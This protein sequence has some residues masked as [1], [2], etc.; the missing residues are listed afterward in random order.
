MMLQ[1]VIYQILLPFLFLF[2]APSQWIKM[3]RRKDATG[4]VLQRLGFFNQQIKNLLTAQSRGLWI[5][6]VSVGEVAIAI[7][8]IREWRRRYPRLPIFLTTT[9]NTAQAVARRELGD[10]VALTYNPLDFIFSVRSFFNL[11][12]PRVLV[13]VES[14]L[15]PNFLWEAKRR[16]VP[17]ALVNARLSLTAERRY[18][19]LQPIIRPLY[20]HLD[21]ICLQSEADRERLLALGARPETLI[22]ADS[23]KFDVSEVRD[24]RVATREVNT[25]LNRASVPDTARILLGGS[26]HPGEEQILARVYLRLRQKHPELFLII[27]P[28]HFER[29]KKIEH[30]LTQLGLRVVRRSLLGDPLADVQPLPNT[31]DVLL[32]DTTGELKRFYAA[33]HITFV[34]KSLTGHGGQNFLEPVQYCHPVIV[35]PHVENFAEIAS[36]FIRERAIIQVADQAALESAVERCLSDPAYAEAVAMRAQSLFHKRLGATRRTIE[37]LDPFILPAVSD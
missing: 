24:T 12:H 15:W 16:K 22:V 7:R 1:K 19:M 23:M 18:R 11:I 37:A 27:C 35:G 3:L 26:T 17:V 29:A 14:E 2:L 36:H 30:E 20:D 34:G 13:L 31:P 5:H 9:T 32:V 33:A 10:T 8:L 6:A 4:S 25:L 28:R 21:I